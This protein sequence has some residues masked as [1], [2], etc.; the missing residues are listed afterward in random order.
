MPDDEDIENALRE[1]VKAIHREG[2]EVTVNKARTTAE[3]ELGLETGYF[4]SHDQWK[5][6]SKDIIQEAH[7]QL[8]ASPEKSVKKPSKPKPAAKP[9]PPAKR[10]K[11][12]A[13]QKTR[14]RQKKDESESEPD[15]V[16][17]DSATASDES[18]VETPPKPATS[19]KAKKST[20]SED[21]NTS[22]LSDV[23]DPETPSENDVPAK[24]KI[25]TSK[26]INGNVDSES[27]L[28]DVIDEPAPKKKRGSGGTKQDTKP[29]KDTATKSSKASKGAET[30]PDEAEIKRLQGWL[31]K[32]GIRKLWGKEL[33]PFETHK[34][35]IKHL[36][37]M[38]GDAGM[39]G[40][41]SNEKAT[42][43]KEARELAADLEAVQEG[44]K[45]WGNDKD[46]A[47]GSASNSEDEDAPAP[48]P[49]RSV[50]SRFVDFGDEDEDDE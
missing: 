38:L 42:G 41:Y 24:T 27:D 7:E 48:P 9:K 35:K 18:E 23:Q 45:H 34:A 36:R 1:A 50:T 17:S 8:D 15:E 29:K 25:G 46:A 3:E 5:T 26:A 37:S 11:A 16:L 13:G 47:S 43:I 30:S 12:P 14:K 10:T 49:R 32:C 21:G 39:T 19:K 20:A 33:K 6:R 31:V 40:R 44:N 2:E 28:S 22:A 4:K